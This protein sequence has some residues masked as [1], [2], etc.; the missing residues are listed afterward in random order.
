M[1]Y[2]KTNYVV[3][4]FETTGFSP[5]ENEVI[6]ISAMKVTHGKDGIENEPEMF[7][8]FVSIKSEIP[9]EIENLTG[10][11]N[12][13]LKFD[14]GALK[15]ENAWTMFSDFIG[16]TMP[17]IGHNS[18]N[19]DRK[20][21]IEAFQLYHLPLPDQDRYIDTAMMYKAKKLGIMQPSNQ[22][23]FNWCLEI[24]DIRAYGV[25]FNLSVTCE[26]L[27]VNTDNLTAHRADSDVIMTNEVY[28][29]LIN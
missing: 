26:E 20:F 22:S 23:H 19:F 14:K 5:A 24:S 17:L 6:Q 1:N 4:D 28:K 8:T 25:K 18:I 27:N 15:P 29:K 21:L 9:T 7:D 11:T 3:F 13:M 16:D 12:E 2:P 10:I